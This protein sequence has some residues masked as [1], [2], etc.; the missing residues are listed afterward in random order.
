MPHFR[1]SGLVWQV[2]LSNEEANNVSGAA[3]AVAGSTAP[4]APVAAAAL[5][6]LAGVIVTVNQIGGDR[7]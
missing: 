6:A 2:E 5:A 1:V 7:G 4:F 3:G